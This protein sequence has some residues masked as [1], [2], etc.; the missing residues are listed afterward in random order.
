MLVRRWQSLYVRQ[1]LRSVPHLEV[2][3]QGPAGKEVAKGVEVHTQAVGAVPCQ[4]A[5]HCKGEPSRGLMFRPSDGRQAAPSQ[6]GQQSRAKQ[7]VGA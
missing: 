5:Y 3:V 6:T 2:S 4:R 7:Q 1:G